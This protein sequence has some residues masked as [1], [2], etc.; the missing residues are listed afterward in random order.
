MLR[1]YRY[2]KAKKTL[3]GKKVKFGL[4][5]I[6]ILQYH[7]AHGGG[8]QGRRNKEQGRYLCVYL[9]GVEGWKGEHLAS[10]MDLDWVS[11]AL[12]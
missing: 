7:L 10:L 1:H 11:W 2:W 3:K 6:P 9:S 8:N 5:E 4:P 12:S